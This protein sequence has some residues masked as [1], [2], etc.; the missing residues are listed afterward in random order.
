MGVVDDPLF[1]DKIGSWYAIQ[2]KGFLNCRCLIK[3]NREGY[4][5]S[6]YEVIHLCFGIIDSNPQKYHPFLT[7]FLTHFF[8]DRHFFPAWQT[9]GSKEIDQHRFPFIVAE[10]ECLAIKEHE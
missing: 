7:V 2:S 10:I 3:A 8:K 1:V 4:A 5:I 9:P 6:C